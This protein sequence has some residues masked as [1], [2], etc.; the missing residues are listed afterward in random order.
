[1]AGPTLGDDDLYAVDL[2]FQF[3]FF[4]QLKSRVK[5]SSN[6]YL[7]FSGEHFGFGNSFRIPSQAAPN[8]MI[9]AFWTDLNPSLDPTGTAAVYTYDNPGDNCIH[10]FVGGS[11]GEICCAS[12][13]GSCGKT[14]G[15][16]S[17]WLRQLP[18]VCLSG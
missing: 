9:A 13:C 15:N 4:G 14:Q 11:G 18:C 1:M 7:T 17:V 10:G 5:I 16:C 6:G 12:T 3:M 8:D 2:P